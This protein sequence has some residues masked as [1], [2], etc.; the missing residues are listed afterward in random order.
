MNKKI[1]FLIGLIYTFFVPQ[2]VYSRCNFKTADY[3]EELSTPS[4]IKDI[5]VSISNSRKFVVN[6]AKILIS[7][8][9]NIDSKFKKKYRADIQVNYPFGKCQYKA[10]AWQNG[11]WK[12]HIKWT[13]SGDIINSLNIKLEEGNILNSVKFKLLLPHTRNGINEILG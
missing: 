13:D 8:Q 10:K 7:E 1:F 5:K 9:K 2:K 6:S 4:N 12:D 11:D 3:I